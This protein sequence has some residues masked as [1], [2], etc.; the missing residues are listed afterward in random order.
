MLTALVA[1]A[2][3]LAVTGGIDYGMVVSCRMKTDSAAYSATLHGAHVTRE[4]QLLNPMMSQAD[5]KVIGEAAAIGHFTTSAPTCVTAASMSASVAF[6]GDTITVAGDYT[7]QAPTR[8]LQIAGI[9][10]VR[11]D[12]RTQGAVAADGV[13]NANMPIDEKFDD[14]GSKPVSGTPGSGL[15]SAFN[16]WQTPSGQSIE[17]RNRSV[18]GGVP[19]SPSGQEMMLELDR[20]SNSRL[21]KRVLLQKGVYELR[22]WYF[23]RIRYDAY[24]PA[25]IC[26]TEAETLV[27]ANEASGASAPQ[28]NGLSVFMDA[29]IKEYVNTPPPPSDGSRIDACVDSGFNW[30]QRSVKIN[31]GAPGA[32]WLTFAAEGASDGVGGLLNHIQLCLKTCDQDPANPSPSR[33]NFPWTANTVLFTDNFALPPG[34]WPND[35]L[36]FYTLNQSGTNSG[37]T[38]LPSGWTTTPVN[39]VELKEITR[40]GQN[41]YVVGIDTFSDSRAPTPNRSIHRR[42]LLSPGFYLGLRLITSN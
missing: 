23:G 38:T 29:A 11:I 6:I 41:T 40:A 24:T 30:I 16:G 14:P 22:Y 18:F 32:F 26:G 10:A 25:W 15:Y 17:I 7:G 33:D 13:V 20:A 21:A 39:H 34:A 37:W 19:P 8:I 31:V 1:P 5:A 3:T 28:T 4:T 12:G 9:P 27:W 36:K 2:L 35:Y 42:F